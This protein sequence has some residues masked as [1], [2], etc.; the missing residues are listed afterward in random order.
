MFKMQGERKTPIQIH[1][2]L[3]RTRK[4]KGIRA[5]DLTNVRKVLKGNTYKRG[6]V[7][8]R[9]PKRVLS[10]KQILKLNSVRKKLLKKADSEKRVTW[11][12][13]LRVGRLAR[14][15]EPETLARNFQQEGLDVKWRP[16]RDGQDLTKPE[17]KERRTM[18]GRWRFLPHDY[19]TS[20]VDAIMDNK[21]FHVPTHHRALRYVRRSRCRGHLRT[22]QEGKA[23]YCRKPNVRKNKVNPGGCVNVAAAIINGKLQF[24]H[25]FGKKWNGSVAASLYRR[26]LLKALQKHRGFKRKYLLLEDNDPTGYKSKKALLAKREVGIKAMPWPRYSPDLN[27]LDFHVWHEVEARVLKRLKGPISVKE[28]GRR[29]RRV[30]K[31][32]PQDKIVEAVCSI[33]ARAKAVYEAKGGLIERD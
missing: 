11:Q 16:A 7:E 2:W 32:L 28:F 30:A 4:Q 14:K 21:K 29:L 31:S 24:W 17:M 3:V 18:C 6:A 20:S 22:R 26:P 9:G 23:G 8:T 15:V 27:P 25:D 12:E 1:K 33:K 19:F 13:V 5:Q 10:K